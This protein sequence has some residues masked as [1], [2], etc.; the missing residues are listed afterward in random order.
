MKRTLHVCSFDEREAGCPICLD[1][2]LREAKAAS[3][4]PIAQL[5]SE[6]ERADY[7]AHEAS[8]LCYCGDGPPHAPHVLPAGLRIK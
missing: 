5:F 7:L 2:D 1:D 6:R 8:G 3:A 4:N